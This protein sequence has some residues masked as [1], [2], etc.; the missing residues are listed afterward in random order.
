[1]YFKNC[2]TFDLFIIS[3]FNKC[4]KLYSCRYVLGVDIDEDAL[5]ICS[6]N[7]EEFEMTNIDLVAVDVKHLFGSNPENSRL[8]KQFDSVIMNPPFG[9]KR[10]EG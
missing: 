1:M 3:I 5:E 7:V 2:Y 6:G 8:Y 10:N 4:L 9:T